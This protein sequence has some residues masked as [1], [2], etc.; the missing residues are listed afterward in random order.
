MRRAPQP[1]PEA[2]DV[3][4]P[5]DGG[6]VW[7]VDAR[8]PDSNENVI[9]AGRRS[10]ALIEPKHALWRSVAVL[11]DGLHRGRIGGHALFLLMFV[12]L[13]DS[14]VFHG[15]ARHEVPFGGGRRRPRSAQAA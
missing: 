1:G 7:G 6:P 13:H 2:K 3:R 8:S 4:D 9:L 10:G 14:L 15:D 11:D 5:R 12:N